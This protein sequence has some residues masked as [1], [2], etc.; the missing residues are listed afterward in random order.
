MKSK[1]RKYYEAYDERYKTAHSIG[2]RWS[3]SECT[4]IVMDTIEKFNI[5]RCDKILEIGCGEGRDS[6]TLLENGYRLNATDV[7][8][9]A[10]L[11]CK[12]NM[13]KY[14]DSFNILDCLSDL[15]DEKYDFIYGIAVI[16]MLVI[17]DDREK[18]YNFIKGH[19]ADDGIALICTMGDGEV[20]MKTDISLAFDLQERNH[21]S[22]KMMVAAT[23]CRMVSFRTFEKEIYQSGLEIIEKGITSAIPDFDKLMYAVVKRNN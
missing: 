19:L 4:P 16:H 22:G 5:K 20:E 11:Y 7:S 12:N 21:E 1:A 23:S 15:H 6:R 9:E 18:F 17:N 14:E 2:V 13:P 10:I 8:N 3:S